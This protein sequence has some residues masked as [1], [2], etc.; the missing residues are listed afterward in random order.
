MSSSI[1]IRRGGLMPD[2]SSSRASSAAPASTPAISYLDRIRVGNDQGNDGACAIFAIAS[3]ATVMYPDQRITD[4][5]RLRLYADTLRRLGKPQGSGLTPGQAFAACSRAGWLPGCRAIRRVHDLRDL[6]RQ[7][8]LAS[9][10]IGPPWHRVSRQG[11]LDHSAP[12]PPPDAGLHMVVIVASG[13]I[14]DLPGDGWIYI[15]NSWGKSWGWNGIGVMEVQLHLAM[16][17]SLHVLDMGGG[18]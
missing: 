8:L 4:A 1:E 7:P 11:C 14:T 3:W 5:D 17:H 16:L 15:E 2:C 18:R 10:R 13:H 6:A 12:F 9:Y